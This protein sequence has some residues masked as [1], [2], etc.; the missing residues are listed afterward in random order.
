MVCHPIW[1][2]ANQF[3]NI[4]PLNECGQQNVK[5]RKVKVFFFFSWFYIATQLLSSALR[6]TQSFSSEKQCDGQNL[7]HAM[8]IVCIHSLFLILDPADSWEQ[9]PPLP[10]QSV[11][12][13][14]MQ[15]RAGWH[16][17]T[18]A[19]HYYQESS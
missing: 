3:L 10:P 16:C 7:C 1:C 18:L 6:S 15:M 4:A 12:I 11:S 14:F 19:L 2:P 17:L 8:C 9:C 13:A 5:V